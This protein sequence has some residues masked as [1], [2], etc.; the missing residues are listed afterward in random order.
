MKD[1]TPDRD[2]NFQSQGA[3]TEG[4]SNGCRVL[5]G[6]LFLIVVGMVFWVLLYRLVIMHYEV[7]RPGGH[8]FGGGDLAGWEAIAAG[9]VAGPLV[10]LAI[11]SLCFRDLRWFRLP[12][13]ALFL[14]FPVKHAV[15][16]FAKY[17]KEYE[18]LTERR[19]KSASERRLHGPP[20]EHVK[21]AQQDG[22]G[23]P[24]TRPESK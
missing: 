15:K 14:I 23:Q 2:S 10:G 8:H 12:F 13:A 4:A 18:A 22:G 20:S 9:I 24:A 5:F 6:G 7:R 17:Q 19:Q 21:E 11:C 16:D 1:E 3:T